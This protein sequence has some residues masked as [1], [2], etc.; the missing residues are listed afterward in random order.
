MIIAIDGPAGA[1]KST[2]A[3]ILAKKLGLLYIDTGAMYRALTLKVLEENIDPKNT[4]R[5]VSLAGKVRIELKYKLSGGLN[6]FIDGV[7]VSKEIRQP[8]IT[9]VVSDI[10]KIKGVRKVMLGLQRKMG[11]SNNSVLEGRDIGTVVFPDAK[12]KF[13]LDARF[14]ERVN[15]RYKE[16]KVSKL[17]DITVNNV[18][19]DLCNRDTIDSTRKIAP[20]KKAKDAIYVDTTNLSINEVVNLLLKH[21]KKNRIAPRYHG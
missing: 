6:V 11:R 3:K 8:S 20:L 12:I 7:D 5:I 21:I 16:L 10:A 14:E 17:K 9:K 13:F 2:I 1:G 18:A 4:G 15:R 19:R